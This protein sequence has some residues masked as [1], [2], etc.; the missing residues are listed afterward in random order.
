VVGSFANK[1]LPELVISVLLVIVLTLLA[2]RT[3][4][5]GRL[6]SKRRGREGGREGRREGGRKRA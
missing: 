4:K 6:V 1:V 3:L 5:K 2:R